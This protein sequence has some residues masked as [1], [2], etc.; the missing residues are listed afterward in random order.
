MVEQTPE[1][2]VREIIAKHYPD[3]KD[4]YN[5][6]RLTIGLEVFAAAEARGKEAAAR[7]A[8][9]RAKASETAIN[10]LPDEDKS[11]LRGSLIASEQIAAAI[12]ASIGQEQTSEVERLREA[13]RSAHNALAN[14]SPHLCKSV[15]IAALNGGQHG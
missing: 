13:L 4:S 12:R 5:G 1:Q 10:V 8:D 14:N 15:L 9:N 11:Y 7:I 3:Y 2:I 6:R